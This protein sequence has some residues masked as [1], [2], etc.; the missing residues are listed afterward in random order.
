MTT[1]VVFRKYP[2]GDIIALFPT[3][4]NRNYSVTCYQHVGQHGSADYEGVIAATSP[5]TESD[6]AELLKELQS[7]GYTDIKI[8]KRF[9]PQYGR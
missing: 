4:I 3:E 7:I 1:P 2:E 5:A 6:H 8:Y 9:R